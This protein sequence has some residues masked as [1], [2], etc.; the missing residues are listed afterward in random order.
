ME[1]IKIIIAS[2][3]HADLIAEMSQKTFYDSFHEQNTKEDM[4]KFLNEQFTIPALRVEVGKEGNIFLLA[5]LNDVPA[6]YVRLREEPLPDENS[7]ANAIELARIYC[8]KEAIGKG[9]GSALMKKSLSIAKELNKEVIWLGVWEFN[10][11]A[12]AF[13]KK[14]GFEQFS[15]HEFLLGNDRQRDVLMKKTL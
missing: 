5:Y 8:I 7:S 6:G 15:E 1:D 11:T 9:V 4:D 2:A 3:E 10:P 12:I 14:F 13:Y